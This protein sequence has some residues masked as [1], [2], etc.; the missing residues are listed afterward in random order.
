MDPALRFDLAALGL[1]SGPRWPTRSLI[2]ELTD[3][4]IAYKDVPVLAWNRW[5][6]A[7]RSSASDDADGR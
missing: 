2:G 7:D 6:A 1:D 4:P 3:V 5:R